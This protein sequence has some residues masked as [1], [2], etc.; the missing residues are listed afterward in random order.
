MS[1]PKSKS[2]SASRIRDAIP[3]LRR[4]VSDKIA[5]HEPKGDARG[6]RRQTL[7]LPPAVHEQLRQLAFNRKISQQELFRQ[8]LNL[9]FAR[10]GLSSWEELEEEAKGQ[11]A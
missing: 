3:S 7:Y 11:M 1:K 9:L 5:G 2:P 8:S 4:T 6:M 10:E